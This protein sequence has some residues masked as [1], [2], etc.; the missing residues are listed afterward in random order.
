MGRLDHRLDRVDRPQRVGDL[1]QGYELRSRREQCVEGVELQITLFGDREGPQV[2]SSLQAELLPGDE[3]GM[4]LQ[5]GDQHFVAATDVLAA[6]RLGQEVGRLGGPAD[7]DDLL[8]PSG[9]E[10]PARRFAGLLI[11]RGGAVAQGV[12]APV[13]V[14]VVGL[15]V[16]DDGVDHRPGL[17]GCSR[18]CRGRPAACRAPPGPAP[19]RGRG[20][21]RGSL[22]PASR[23]DWRCGSLVAWGQDSLV[24]TSVLIQDRT[25]AWGTPAACLGIRGAA[26]PSQRRP[27]GW[28]MC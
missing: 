23:F 7:E 16:P 11:G 10:E 24:I 14:R 25:E 28:G 20:R 26:I 15:V 18:R 27:E 2:R 22:H 19:G 6:E 21:D 9:V 8:G 3:V 17:F 5:L 13:D 4:V 12:G 1:G